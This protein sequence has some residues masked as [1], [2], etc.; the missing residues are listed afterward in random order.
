MWANW[1]REDQR[2]YHRAISPWTCGVGRWGRAEGMVRTKLSMILTV[3]LSLI[4]GVAWVYGRSNGALRA[5][6]PGNEY[7][8]GAGWENQGPDRKGP[9]MDAEYREKNLLFLDRGMAPYSL[10]RY[11]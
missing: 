2:P 6:T 9:P 5:T 7:G 11:I 8:L 3:L 1:R 4:L 10:I